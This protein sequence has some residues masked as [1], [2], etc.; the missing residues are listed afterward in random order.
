[1]LGAAS[2]MVVSP[3]FAFIFSEGRRRSLEVSI[4]VDRKERSIKYAVS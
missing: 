2:I 4:E 1:M 3:I